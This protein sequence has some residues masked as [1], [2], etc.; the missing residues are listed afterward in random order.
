MHRLWDIEEPE[1]DDDLEVEEFYS[2]TTVR[3]QD[4][5]YTVCIPFKDERELGSSRP[6]ALAR[7][8]QLE[9]KLKQKPELL[10]RY[11]VR[12]CIVYISTGV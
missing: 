9:K 4:G 12:R 1:K 10:A 3:N 6:R 11:N 2:K 8:L 7:W 5:P